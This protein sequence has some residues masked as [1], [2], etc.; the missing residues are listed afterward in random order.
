MLGFLFAGL[1]IFTFGVIIV[2]SVFNLLCATNFF[3]KKRVNNS[4][5]TKKLIIKTNSL[6]FNKEFFIMAGITIQ[7]AFNK[8]QT[9]MITCVTGAFCIYPYTHVTNPLRFLTEC[10]S[11]ALFTLKYNIIFRYMSSSDKFNKNS[12]FR[13]QIIDIGANLVFPLP[14]LLPCIPVIRHKNGP[15]LLSG[16]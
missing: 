4:F 2:N 10:V 12:T 6:G 13:Q 15:K 5:L 7:S 16:W 9:V 3:F 1:S 11:Y 8:H 14:D